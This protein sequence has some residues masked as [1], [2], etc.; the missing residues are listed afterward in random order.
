[1]MF[2]WLIH[3]NFKQK[4]LPAVCSAPPEFCG[5]FSLECMLSE[6]KVGTQAHTRSRLDK[7]CFTLVVA[8][9]K[10]YC[11]CI[12]CVEVV[13]QLLDHGAAGRINEANQF[14]QKFP[15]YYP[16][17]MAVL[18]NSKDNPQIVQV[19]IGAFHRINLPI[20]FFTI[21]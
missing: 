10:N 7:S 13:R 3:L 14:D 9:E 12:F 2:S 20:C 15:L 4:C 5:Y 16:L 1:M 18:S 19:G 11:I 21:K 6:W 17:E 8:Q